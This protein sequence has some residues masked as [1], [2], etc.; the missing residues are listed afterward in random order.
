MYKMNF[1]CKSK[2]TRITKTFLKNSEEGLAPSF[3]KTNLKFK[4]FR[5]EYYYVAVKKNKLLHTTW[6]ESPMLNVEEKK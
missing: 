5:M 4:G 3:S 2:A 1:I 6:H